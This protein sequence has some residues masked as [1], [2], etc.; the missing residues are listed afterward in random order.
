MKDLSNVSLWVNEAKKCKGGGQGMFLQ[1]WRVLLGNSKGDSRRGNVESFQYS[2]DMNMFLQIQFQSGVKKNA[3]FEWPERIWTSWRDGCMDFSILAD[4]AEGKKDFGMLSESTWAH[5]VFQRVWK[6]SF[7]NGL[8]CLHG[9][10]MLWVVLIGLFTAG[11]VALSASSLPWMFLC[12]GTQWN[13]ML[14]DCRKR[15]KVLFW[16]FLHTDSFWQ[17]IQMVN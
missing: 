4:V 5:S 11:R 15:L 10:L 6:Y 3:V 12:P 8:Q 13:W 9:I 7:S 14:I 16:I 2:L 1:E 17:A